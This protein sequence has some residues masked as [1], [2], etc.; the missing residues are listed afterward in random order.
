LKRMTDKA[1]VFWPV[2]LSVL[3]ADAATKAVAARA[4][5]PPGTPRPIIADVVRLTLAYNRGAAMGLP[6][7]AHPRV[8]LGVFGLVVA[9]V[10]FRVYVRSPTADRLRAA[11][12]ALVIA[13]AAGNAVERLVSRQG[14]VDFIDM[15]LGSARFWTFNVADVGVTVGAVL[16][17]IMLS[18]EEG[19]DARDGD[20]PPPSSTRGAPAR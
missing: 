15:G 1:R 12:L 7:G 17:A 8:V 6:L 20:G 14:V 4:L 16:L 13:G 9:G 10:L 3:A 19:S 18:K 11:A 5:A 2:V